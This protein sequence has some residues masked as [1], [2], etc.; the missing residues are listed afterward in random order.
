M[1]KYASDKSLKELLEIY[2][3]KA[4]ASAI[5]IRIF[6]LILKLAA[7]IL[8]VIET[9]SDSSN[10]QVLNGRYKYKLNFVKNTYN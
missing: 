2:I 5:N 3:N 7:C 4:S 6:N 1:K 8:Y 9:C 10:I